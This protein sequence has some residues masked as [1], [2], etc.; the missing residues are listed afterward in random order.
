MTLL[1]AIEH[2]DEII[3]NMECCEC[4]N[5]HIQLKIWLLELKKYREEANKPLN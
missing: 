3:E 1:E 4:R 5:E 2:L